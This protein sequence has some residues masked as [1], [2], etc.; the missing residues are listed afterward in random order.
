[1]YTYIF[2]QA[3][4][5][6][7][8]CNMDILRISVLMLQMVAMVTRARSRSGSINKTI[9]QASSK[10]VI[11]KVGLHVINSDIISYYTDAHGSNVMDDIEVCIR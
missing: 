11:S 8:S 6:T 9:Y 10:C 7:W 2:E 4:I 5:I 1:M 3:V